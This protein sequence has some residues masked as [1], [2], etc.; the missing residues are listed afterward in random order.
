MVEVVVVGGDNDW[1]GDDQKLTLVARLVEVA[2]GVQMMLDM[3]SSE[4]NGVW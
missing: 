2:A 1:S 4:I 3:V